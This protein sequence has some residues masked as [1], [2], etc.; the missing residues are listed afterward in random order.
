MKKR[1]ARVIAV[2]AAF[3]IAFSGL[4]FLAGELDVHAASKKV[5]KKVTLQAAAS[6]Q[7]TVVLKWNKIKKPHCCPRGRRC[8]TPT[9]R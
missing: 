8:R 7:D 6:G 9:R 4:P 1:A 3:C 2:I 5:A